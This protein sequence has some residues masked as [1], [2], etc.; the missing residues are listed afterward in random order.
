MIKK[1]YHAI[2]GDPNGRPCA[3]GGEQINVGTQPGAKSD[4]ELRP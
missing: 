4:A 3:A 2:V 1:F